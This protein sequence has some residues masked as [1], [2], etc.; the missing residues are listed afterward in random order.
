[1]SENIQRTVARAIH[2]R[3][4]RLGFDGQRKTTYKKWSNET[5]ERQAAY[6]AVAE[7][8]IR[9]YERAKKRAYP[10]VKEQP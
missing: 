8:A 4:C 10:V 9:S 3:V 1:M 2:H 7:G 5:P 6:D